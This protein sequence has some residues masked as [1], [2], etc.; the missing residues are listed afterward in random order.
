[1]YPITFAHFS[2]V[3]PLVFIGLLTASVAV[4][5]WSRRLTARWT[6]EITLLLVALF[7]W[8][9][10]YAAELSLPTQAMKLAMAK[11]QY[12]GITAVPLFWFM[13]AVRFAGYH[14]W[15]TTRRVVLLTIL[16]IL[17]LIL[18][19]TN[20][21]HGLV[22][23]DMRLDSSGPIV[24]LQLSHGIWFWVFNVFAQICII[25]GSVMLMV[26]LNSIH[27]RHHWR[28]RLLA[29]LPLIPLLGNLSY[30]LGFVPI[31]GLDLTPYAFSVSGFFLAWGIYRLE[32][33]DVNPIARQ[34]AVGSIKD[35]LIV[36]DNE[37]RI[38]DL[39][40]AACSIIGKEPDKVIGKPI[41]GAIRNQPELVAC[42]KRVVEA[43]G[44]SVFDLTFNGR[45][46]DVNLS[47]VT[48]EFDVQRG[49]I[50]ALRDI[51]ERKQAEKALEQQKTLFEGI[52]KIA[53]ALAEGANP[54]IRFQNA[55]NT[56]V[57]LTDAENGCLFLLNEQQNL[58]RAYYANEVM[59]GDDLNVFLD[60]ISQ[61]GLL[62]WMI[63]Y[64]KLVIIGNADED[65]RW[66]S[67][68][69]R[70][71]HTLSVLSIPVIN[72]KQLIGILTLEH[73]QPNFFQPDVAEMLQAAT[74]QMALALENV[75]IY[76]LE[77]QRA[78]HQK[79]L[80]QVLR[81]L[82]LHLDSQT[83]IQ[84]TVNSIQSHVAW[85]AVHVVVPDEAQSRFSIKA[86]SC[87]NL[88]TAKL[89]SRSNEVRKIISTAFHS[90]E[91]QRIANIQTL[92]ADETALP[93]RSIIAV[94]MI[95]HKER[96]GV[97]VAQD[98]KTA[99]FDAE[100]TLLAESLAEACA[101]A[102]S[103]AQLHNQTKTQ[104]REQKAIMQAVSAITSTLDLPTLLN[105]LAQ[106][107]SEAINATSV[108][109]HRYEP[110]TKQSHI[111]ARFHSSYATEEERT[112]C[113]QWRQQINTNHLTDKLKRTLIFNVSAK[114]KDGGYGSKVNPILTLPLH[115]GHKTIAFA[116]LW[117][118]RDKREFTQKEI[119][120]ARTIAQHAAIAIENANLFQA[121]NEEQGRLTALI[122]SSRDGIILVGTNRRIL[123]VNEMALTMLQQDD[124]PQGWVDRP[125]STILKSLK[126]SYPQEI[127]LM[128]II[129]AAQDLKTGEFELGEKIICWQ[130]LLVSADDQPIGHLLLLRDVTDER[131]LERMR[132]DLTRTMVHDLRNPIGAAK[133][134]LDL[135]VKIGES[136][137]SEKSMSLVNRAA[138]ITE[139][140]LDLVNQILD[141]SQLESGKMPINYESFD[142]HTLVDDVLDVQ[143]SLAMEKEIALETKLPGNL[144][145]VWADRKLMGRV[146]QNLVGNALKFTPEGGKVTIAVRNGR[147]HP[148]TP[149]QLTITDTGNGIPATIRPRLFQKFATG[150]QSERGNGLGLAFCKMV[151]DNHGETIEILD[152]SAKGT[153]FL[154][155][156]STAVPEKARQQ[157]KLAVTSA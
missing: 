121:I 77:I 76:E 45:S 64:Q 52:A 90:G 24:I 21:W 157:A 107:M 106:Q 20:D 84:N 112:Q 98:E 48:D 156:L 104:L 10:G 126:Q 105:Q 27:A 37:Q 109:I 68:P 16:P 83:F 57:T 2:I 26:H 139:R 7:I 32:L 56:M 95:Y 140:T 5:T 13:F 147:S 39:N 12:V 17:T 123:I 153:T 135:L 124:A 15:L 88:E 1:M 53:K 55:I 35:G 33:F 133:L 51:S 82:N 89:L 87:A 29:F 31:P 49:W 137:L 62:G 128:Q 125:L 78:A 44:A 148:N 127:R 69:Y 36:L 144:P 54:Q 91:T 108:L 75:R 103:N 119:G 61:E 14:R 146:L 43:T 79:T 93:F 6:V 72:Q 23:A 102:L 67:S 145:N 141:I 143:A 100:E 120:L 152:S 47:R 60:Q 150:D 134:S 30:L 114:D 25:I 155:T 70:S 86:T 74:D 71:Q 101:L 80:Y 46:Y 149:L 18:V 97:F 122:Q 117:N 92:L 132:N 42:Y 94:P 63:K 9:F 73:S 142:L 65:S 113:E 58:L 8:T 99:V 4:F 59:L 129:P 34:T 38:I 50:I 41:I 154:L 111:L 66:I 85:T 110:D 138:H 19:L 96:L 130:N 131:V 136:E 116:E 81:Q 40:P 28:V 118:S 115:I 151:Q 3:L 22:W 11:L